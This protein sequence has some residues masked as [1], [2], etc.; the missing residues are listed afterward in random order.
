MVRSVCLCHPNTAW[1]WLCMAVCSLNVAMYDSVQLLAGSNKGLLL[2]SRGWDYSIAPQML[3]LAEGLGNNAPQ[4]LAC[5]D[6]PN[7]M[8]HHTFSQTSPKWQ[9]GLCSTPH[10][11][12]LYLPA[13]VL[14][15][16]KVLSGAAWATT[17]P[18][19]TKVYLQYVCVCVC[20]CVCVRV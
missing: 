4:S 6:A 7:V 20:V 13:L 2:V 5:T 12:L 10:A 16:V 18:C 15:V 1:T 19:S 9:L 17:A 3:C 8:H 14:A 11:R